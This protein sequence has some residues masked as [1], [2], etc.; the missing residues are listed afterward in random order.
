M[1]HAL[2]PGAGPMTPM[3]HEERFPPPRLSACCRFSQG[4]F[5]GVRGN[6]RDAPKPAIPIEPT[7]P[8]DPFQTPASDFRIT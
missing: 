7:E 4:T 5:A 3:G 6:G 2:P 8:F 1:A